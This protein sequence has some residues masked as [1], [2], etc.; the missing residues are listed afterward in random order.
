MTT[1]EDWLTAAVSEL[2]PLYAA[3]GQP[4]PAQIRLACGFTS[5]GRRTKRLAECWSPDASADG[6]TEILISPRVAYAPD[7]LVLLLA[8][9]IHASGVKGHGGAYAGP[10]AA[11]GLVEPWKTPTAGR[12]FQARYGLLLGALGPYPHAELGAAAK[13]AAPTYLLKAACPQCGYTIRLTAKWAA[14]GLPTCP[15]DGQ[16]FILA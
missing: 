6:T 7:V 14:L 15:T 16:Q 5:A 2:R 4:L 11:L 3:I 8:S 10:A 9:L 12:D 1:R 13:P